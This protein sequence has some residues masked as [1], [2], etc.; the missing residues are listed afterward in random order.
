VR[1]VNEGARIAEP[2]GETEVDEMDKANGGAPPDKNILGFNI[3]VNDV[4]RVDKFEME[5][6]VLEFIR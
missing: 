5:K 2:S 4:S 1:D 6:L 3:A